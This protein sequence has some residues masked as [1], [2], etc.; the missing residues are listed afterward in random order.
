[1]SLMIPKPQ[2]TGSQ[3]GRYKPRLCAVSNILTSAPVPVVLDVD[4]D[5]ILEVT[6]ELLR[7]FLGQRIARNDY[8]GSRVSNMN[9]AEGYGTVAN[10]QRRPQ[11]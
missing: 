7:L 8:K 6:A 9:A 10:L 2:L 5:R 3:P 4:V 11:R 1:M